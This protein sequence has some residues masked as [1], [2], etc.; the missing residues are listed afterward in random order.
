MDESGYRSTLSAFWQEDD[1]LTEFRQQLSTEYGHEI[2]RSVLRDET[3]AA[4][5]LALGQAILAQEGTLPSRRYFKSSPGQHMTMMMEMLESLPVAAWP[6]LESAIDIGSSGLAFGQL[7]RTMWGLL[8]HKPGPWQAGVASRLAKIALSLPAGG[9]ELEMAAA[10]FRH[11]EV[12]DLVMEQASSWTGKAQLIHQF[13][14]ARHQPS[15]ARI[16]WDYVSKAHD[17]VQILLSDYRE[18]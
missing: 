10:G 3:A 11:K 6:D 18:R 13:A 9:D 4:R 8:N 12:F 1:K 14:L 5:T 17:I 15:S 7:A 2:H 16:G